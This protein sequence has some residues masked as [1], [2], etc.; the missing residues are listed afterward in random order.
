[1]SDT[2]TIVGIAEKYEADPDHY[3]ALFRALKQAFEAGQ[4]SMRGKAESELR[5]YVIHQPECDR[6]NAGT[7][8]CGLDAALAKWEP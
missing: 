4:I 3:G 2:E 6:W 8:T 7:C 5:K 1:M